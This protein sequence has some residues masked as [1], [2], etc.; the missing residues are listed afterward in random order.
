M[1]VRLKRPL[2]LA[3]A[4]FFP[5]FIGIAS[6]QLVDQLRTFAIGLT[7]SFLEFQDYLT[8]FVKT[9]I[10]Y[11]MEWPKLREANQALQAELE[12]LK[13][14]R[15]GFEEMKHENARLK[16][17]L[18]LKEK[19]RGGARAARVIA[20]D[21]SHWSH[22][23]VIGKG[24]R[25]GVRKNTVLVHPDG[26]VGKVVAAGPYTARAILLL[27]RQ[28]RVSALNQRTRDI[29]LIEGAGSF[30]LKMTYLERQ[31][32]I[33]VGDVILSSGVGGVYPKGIPIGTIEVIGSEKDPLKLYALVKPFV[34]FSKLEEVLCVSSTSG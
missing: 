7:G 30:M 11:L 33:Q 31:S 9:E 3:S 23:I 21:P 18:H 22:F 12:N 28:S 20:R 15:A 32:E 6:P 13:T 16:A 1:P 27:D 26:L 29:G 24:T 10:H 17:L 19:S 5:L 34:S 8:R 14:E 2:F 4:I 25:D